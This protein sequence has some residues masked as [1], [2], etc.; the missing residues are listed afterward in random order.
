MILLFTNPQFRLLWFGVVFTW[1][2]AVLL[3][4]VMGWLALSLTDSPFWVGAAMGMT[5]LGMMGTSAVGGVL[6]DRLPRRNIVVASGLAHVALAGLLSLTILLGLVVLWHVLTVALLTGIAAGLR[7]PAFSALTLDVVGRARLL[8]GNAANFAGLSIAGV[9]GP[10][11]GGAVVS[12]WDIGW[13]FVIVAGTEL[14]GV[15]VMSRLAVPSPSSAAPAD[16]ETA[17]PS[18][19]SP[20][21]AFMEGAGYVFSTSNVR[22]LILMGLV[23]ELFVWAHAAMLPVMVRDVLGAGVAGFGYLQSASFAGLFVATVVVSNMGDVSR[24]GLLLVT[25]AVG[26]GLLI[27]AFAASRDFTLSLLLLAAAYAMAALYEVTL[28]TLVQTVVPDAMRGRVISFQAFTWGVNAF[29]G[30]HTGAIA[31]R[32]GAPLAIAI[33]AGVFVAYA[34]R[35]IPTAGRLQG[36]EL[37]VTG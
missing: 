26:F 24:K 36:P 20:W 4:M 35:V 33:G 22:S 25:G 19:P 16:P 12:V 2:S 27:M 10:L 29:S 8:S 17:A 18:R 3:L 14:A 5:G 13:A 1:L 21:R 37:E 28:A 7:A 15:A 11:V 23:G 34:I 31:N 9:V 32:L 30:F 6:A